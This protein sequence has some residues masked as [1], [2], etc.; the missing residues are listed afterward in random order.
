MLTVSTKPFPRNEALYEMVCRHFLATVSPDAKVQEATLPSR[1]LTHPILG[2][3]KIIDSKSTFQRICYVSSQEGKLG[4]IGLL[5]PTGSG[6]DYSTVL[7]FEYVFGSD[8][9][10]PV[11][12]DVFLWAFHDFPAFGVKV[13]HTLPKTYVLNKNALLHA[14]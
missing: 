6:L 10:V 11:D 5:T 4:R 1:E 13:V 7:Q 9:D 14:L 2:K 8:M 12:H 3:R